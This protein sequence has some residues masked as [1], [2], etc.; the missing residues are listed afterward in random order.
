MRVEA[1]TRI[2]RN[3][4][5]NG[6]CV[7]SRNIGS[8]TAHQSS[9]NA[10]NRQSKSSDGKRFNCKQCDFATKW[11]TAMTIHKRIHGNGK[12]IGVKA[13]SEGFY[14]CFLCV[15]Q[16]TKLTYL[17]NHMQSHKEDIE[18]MF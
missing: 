15:R 2:S 12:W 8:S 11:K 6:I 9:S 3:C 5:N 14:H 4:T 17:N 18:T 1:F 13:D 10:D 16:F 7:F